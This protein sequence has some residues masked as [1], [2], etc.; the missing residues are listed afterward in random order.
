[1]ESEAAPWVDVARLKSEFGRRF[2]ALRASR[3]PAGRK[4]LSDMMGMS[5]HGVGRWE[6]GEIIP[7]AYEL[8]RLSVIFRVDEAFLVRGKTDGL[9][10]QR[11][12]ELEQA[13]VI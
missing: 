5:E 1:M 2:T 8:V 3:W 9:S 7:N 11:I 13:G 4:P 12:R 6:R 10:E